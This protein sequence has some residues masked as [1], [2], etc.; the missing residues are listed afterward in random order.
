MVFVQLFCFVVISAMAILLGLFATALA[1]DSWT[2][3]TID[4]N[5][6]VTIAVLGTMVVWYPLMTHCLGWVLRRR[7]PVHKP[8]V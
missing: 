4:W 7:K 8:V 1:W 6:V 3:G 2:R 5:F